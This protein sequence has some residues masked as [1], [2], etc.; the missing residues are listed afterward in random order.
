MTKGIIATI[1]SLLGIVGMV[2]I[3]LA[4][5]EIR[6]FI[7]LQS[8]S[9]LSLKLPSVFSRNSSTQ[10]T[11]PHQ[12]MTFSNGNRYEGELREGKPHGKGI[13]TFADGRRYEGEFHQG[14]FHGK[15]ILVFPDQTRY[16][17]EFRHGRR[18][19]QGLMTAPG[20]KPLNGIWKEDQ[21]V[22]EFP[23]PIDQDR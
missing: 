7:G 8:E 16:E 17:G 3:Q 23:A 1:G 22:S 14:Q 19:G 20:S 18:S 15:G 13:L 5:P 4:G 2:T 6:C 11:P 12:V 9:C 21:L 10:T